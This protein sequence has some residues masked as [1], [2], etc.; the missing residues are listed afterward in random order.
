MEEWTQTQTLWSAPYAPYAF[1][2]RWYGAALQ[3]N[4]LNLPLEHDIA[5]IPDADWEKGPVHIAGLIADMEERHALKAEVIALREALT[6]S[7][8]QA[9][10]VAQRS[11]NNPPELLDAA[12]E[13]QRQI[14][15]IFDTLDNAEAELSLAKPSPSRLKI[16][17]QAL[18]A[19]GLA[20]AKYCGGLADTALQKAAEELGTTGTK[21]AIGIA[22]ASW[23]AQAQPVQTLGQMILKYALKLA[24]GG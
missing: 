18:L 6:L 5:L 13:I 19:A 4:H 24:Q 7:Q 17:G 16:I 2:L 21:W 3:G 1:W 22:A 15:I 11:H 9:A 23:A 12:P 20:I 10:S 8:A 14:T